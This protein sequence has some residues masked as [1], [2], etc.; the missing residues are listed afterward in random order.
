M[1]RYKLR[2]LLILLAILPPILAWWCWP[3]LERLIYPQTK[4]ESVILFEINVDL[5]NAST[6]DSSA[7][8]VIRYTFQTSTSNDP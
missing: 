5:A 6:P 4:I 3:A 1:F 7:Q 2:T 8:P